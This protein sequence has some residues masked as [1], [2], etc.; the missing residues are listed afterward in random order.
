MPGSGKTA[1]GKKLAN[2]LQY[3]FLDT[4]RLIETK[5]NAT[6]DEIFRTQGELFFRQAEQKLLKEYPFPM[7][8]V[9]ATGGGM[10]CEEENSAL[11]KSLGTVVYLKQS[12]QVLCQRLLHSP[13]KRPA[14]QGKNE[15]EILRYLVETLLKRQPFY[16]MAD[17]VVTGSKDG[18]TT[19]AQILQTDP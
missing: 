5:L 7:K 15:E 17:I 9:I 19:L 14:L 16:E 11:L 10:P 12:P 2:K 1:I 4:D 13:N 18:I 3:S 6:I 8:S